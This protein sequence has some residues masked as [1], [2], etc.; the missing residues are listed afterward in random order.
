LP[1]FFAILEITLTSPFLPF[2]T[3][4]LYLPGTR[5]K[6]Y[7]RGWGAKLTTATA[8]R[9]IGLQLHLSGKEKKE[10]LRERMGGKTFHCY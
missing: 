9:E 8:K 4:S 5:K 7:R 6:D 2:N 3:Q 1:R 10:R